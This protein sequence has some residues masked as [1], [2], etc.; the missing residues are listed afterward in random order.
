MSKQAAVKTNAVVTSNLTVVSNDTNANVDYKAVTLANLNKLISERET[1][2]TT[3]Y[4]KSNDVL[5]SILQKCLAMNTDLLGNDKD[6]KQR[7]AA[8]AEFIAAN[9]YRF[10]EATPV[11]TKVVKCV[12]GVD[13]RRVSAYSIV[14]REAIKQSVNAAALPSW[15][16]N[17]G[18][19]EQIRLSKS[20]NAKTTKQKAES[21]KAVMQTSD[22]LCVATSE[23]LA[24]KAE[25]EFAEQDCVLLAT[26]QADGT[27]AVRAVLRNAGAVNAA[28]VAYYSQSK[29]VVQNDTAKREAA[30]DEKTR[31]ALIAKAAA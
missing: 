25:V 8:L 29:S 21:A 13:R 4:R 20:A 27:F 24:Q 23:A 28:L 14:L 7:R 3:V 17:N 16:E 12:F 9:N 6:S 22:V 26:Q 18:G 15:I 10:T 1:W 2:E 19:V 5:Y 11:I 30:N 31:E